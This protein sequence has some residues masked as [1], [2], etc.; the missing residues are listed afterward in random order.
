[1]D[2]TG[3]DPRNSGE[4]TSNGLSERVVKGFGDGPLEI[5][6]GDSSGTD[7]RRKG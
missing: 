2:F 3:T 4:K 1:M 6:E 7:P 5:K